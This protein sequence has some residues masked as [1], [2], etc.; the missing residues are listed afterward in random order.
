MIDADEAKPEVRETLLKLDAFTLRVDAVTIN[1]SKVVYLVKQSAVLQEAAKG[2]SFYEHVLAS[3]IWHEMAHLDGADERGARH[4]EEATLDTLRA[5]WN[6]G[7]GHRPSLS[8]RAGE[9]TG[10]PTEGGAIA[11]RLFKRST[12]LNPILCNAAGFARKRP[13]ERPCLGGWGVPLRDRL[14][15]SIQDYGLRPSRSCGPPF[16]ILPRSLHLPGAS[17]REAR[18][19][20]SIKLGCGCGPDGLLPSRPSLDRELSDK[21]TV[22]EQWNHRAPTS[23]REAAAL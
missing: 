10:R 1:R 5:R 7:P 15:P 12:S 23:S 8:E 13:Y 14:K 6:L 2:S 9:T 20:T 22:C 4:A 18:Q 21:A 3:I 19:K 17:P 11:G 16:P